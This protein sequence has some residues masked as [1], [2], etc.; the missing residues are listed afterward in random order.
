M[1]EKS[2]ETTRKDWQDYYRSI[3]DDDAKMKFKDEFERCTHIHTWFNALRI[4]EKKTAIG[5]GCRVL[6]AGCGW[7]RMLLGLVDKFS[8]L[9]VTAADYQQEAID[10]GKGILG[11]ERNGNTIEWK[12]ADLQ[13]LPFE[14]NSFDVI[15][16]ARV[17][18]H[19]NNPSQGVAE[20]VRVLRPEGRI[21]MF[22]QNKLCP[23]N[24]NYYSRLYSPGQVRKWFNGL[25]L[26]GLKVTSMDFFPSQISFKA[27]QPVN[28]FAESVLETLP[29][30]NMFGGKV[31]AWGEKKGPKKD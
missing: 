16:S 8:G 20:L 31:V 10:I 14:D 21:V 25:P 28:M 29:L 24:L 13:D 6:D 3:G 15:Y 7:G 17:F 23:L 12:R 26:N 5:P 22:L 27:L 4:I 2:Y 18:Q 19:L 30:I 9:A 1:R 11:E